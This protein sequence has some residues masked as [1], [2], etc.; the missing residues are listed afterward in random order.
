MKSSRAEYDPLEEK[1]NVISHAIGFV[2]SVIGTGLLF[3]KTME[4]GNSWAIVSSLIFGV[5]MMVLY[6]ASTLY[7]ASTSENKRRKLRVFDHASIFILIAGTYT[8][9]TLISLHGSIGWILLGVTWSMAIG[10][11][12]LKIFYTGR[13]NM[14]STIM[15][16]VMGWSIVFAAFPLVE[17]LGMNG[18]LWLLAG[19]IIYSLGAVLYMFDTVKYTHAIFHLFVLMGTACHFI[20]IYYFVLT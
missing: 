4:I 9:F 18:F 14:L 8:P 13:Y 20:S 19:G 17:S 10:G 15:Y 3:K 11:I 5:A 7:H 2:L 16:V 6:A 1:L 12:V